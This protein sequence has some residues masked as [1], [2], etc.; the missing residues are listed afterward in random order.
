MVAETIAVH[1]AHP[2]G[3][4]GVLLLLWRP[5]E[6][7]RVSFREWFSDDWLAPGRDGVA[8]AVDLWERV[9]KWQA[10]RW[11]L[12]EPPQRLANWLRVG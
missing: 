5:D 4:P 8:D 6:L 2:S 10:E 3:A 9:Q 7:G 1:A 11:I 12:S